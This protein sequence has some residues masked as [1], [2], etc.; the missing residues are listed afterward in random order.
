[1]NM[2]NVTVSVPVEMKSKMDEYAIINW[3]EVARQ[4]FAG[5]LK[6]LEM[7]KAITAESKATEQDVEELSKKVKAGV[8][9]RHEERRR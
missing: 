7:L 6:R 2:V 9:K 4:A 8:L 1:M 5:Q 3:S